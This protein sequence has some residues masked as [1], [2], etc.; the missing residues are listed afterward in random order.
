[1]DTGNQTVHQQQRQQQGSACEECRRR[2]LRCDR[3]KPQCLACANSGNTCI[4]KEEVSTRGPKKGHVD[5]LKN[6]IAALEARL[7]EY[8]KER[9][10]RSEQPRTNEDDAQSSD[11]ENVPIILPMFSTDPATD[12]NDSL[13]WLPSIDTDLLPPS[14][15]VHNSI[16]DPYSALM[17]QTPDCDPI[18]TLLSPLICYDLDQ[19]YFDRVHLFVPF[20]HKA[21]YLSWSKHVDK[22]KQKLCL[23]YAMW[24]LTASLS[25]QFHMIQQELYVEA[26]RLLDTLELERQD[27][28]V[29]GLE[30]PQAW[31]LLSIYEMTSD[32]FQRSLVSAGKAFRLVHLM[33][34]Y[35]LDRQ[36]PMSFQ[37]DWVD[38]ESMRR[39]FWVAH[40]LDLFTSVVHDLPLTF[41]EREIG[42][43]LP[44]PDS[45]F[46]SGQPIVMCFIY[47]VI[48]GVDTVRPHSLASGAE[49]SSLAESAIMATICGRTSK[50]RREL[51]AEYGGQGPTQGFYRQHQALGE[52]LVA[53]LQV[54]S[55]QIPSSPDSHPDSMLVFLAIS[56]YMA[57]FM[58]GE[59]LEA[60]QLG[61]G[62]PA[63][64]L[65]SSKQRSR[66]GAGELGMLINILSQLNYFEIHPFTPIPLLLS[67][68]FCLPHASAG[69]G[70]DD[71]YTALMPLI[72]SAL[73]CQANVNGL[74]R[75]F[76]RSLNH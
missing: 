42:T 40:S 59:I 10:D 3:K 2:K 71:A 68:R 44:A 66:D 38:K 17:F 8:E 56:A 13:A 50:L 15:N 26:R 18:K 25:S 76:L 32:Q 46:M 51:V 47:E 33:G 29:M 43:L 19:L 34:L 36:L 37:S 70:P 74:A 52:L 73:Q 27:G 54:I 41:D 22:P 58:L 69:A 57:I 39:T 9:S 12:F 11:G 5:A 49:I 14:K 21:R 72:I 6:K 55:G 61:A 16:E 60:K 24:T 28:V 45:Q 30:Q 65:T 1:M 7:S 62:S 64:A 75:N 48:G 20:L 35:K 67:A 53:R 23:Q 63:A 4:T 31:L